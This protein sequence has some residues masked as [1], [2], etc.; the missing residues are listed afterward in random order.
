MSNTIQNSGIFNLFI[1][2]AKNGGKTRERDIFQHRFFFI[3]DTCSTSICI[4][5]SSF[6]TA[7][8][9]VSDE[10]K[11]VSIFCKFCF[12]IPASLF[13]FW[14]RWLLCVLEDDYLAKVI[15][16]SESAITA[17]TSDLPGL[18]LIGSFSI[19]ETYKKYH[20]IESNH[21]KD[22]EINRKLSDLSQSSCACALI[23]W[24]VLM[25]F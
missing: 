4:F 8:S 17:R 13:F 14:L 2:L 25:S 5:V 23:V 10:R 22:F 15:P 18:N 24:L 9:A 3:I 11:E 16:F 1:F 20:V 12:R 19:T 7:F 6:R 21:F